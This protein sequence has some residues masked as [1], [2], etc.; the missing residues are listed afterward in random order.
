[1][2]WVGPLQLRD[3]VV[4][5]LDGAYEPE[6]T[7]TVPLRAVAPDR[8]KGLIETTG[9]PMYVQP[10]RQRTGHRELQLRLANFSLREQLL[11]QYKA[12]EL[13]ARLT[14]TATSAP[15]KALLYKSEREGVSLG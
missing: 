2:P 3:S 8:L 12:D 6:T 15:L 10:H 4:A 7:D 14:A 1:M 13:F 11:L 9:G 5:I